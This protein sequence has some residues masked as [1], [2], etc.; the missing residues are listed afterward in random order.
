MIRLYVLVFLNFIKGKI[1][2]PQSS[3]HQTHTIFYILTY[4]FEYKS[5][6]TV[7]H[8]K[9]FHKKNRTSKLILDIYSA[10]TTLF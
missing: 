2:T 3:M 4:L 8:K 5:D 7:P 10:F 1:T 9:S 6:T